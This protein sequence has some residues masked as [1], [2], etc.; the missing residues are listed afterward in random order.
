MEVPIPSVLITGALFQELGA[1]TNA[2]IFSV[3]SQYHFWSPY[4]VPGIVLCSVQD[5]LML[6]L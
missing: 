3:T 1:E 2:C 6:T 4:Y 5:I